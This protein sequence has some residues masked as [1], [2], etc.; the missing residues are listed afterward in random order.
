MS[1]VSRF[2]LNNNEA[3]LYITLILFLIGAVNVFSASFVLAGQLLHDSYFFLKHHL[4]A[5]AIGFIAL[6][7]VS[8]MDY[9]HVRRL[10]LF[11]ILATTGLLIAVHLGGVDANGARRWLNLAG[12]KFQPSEIAKLVTIIM[13][14]SY[15]GGL[16][17]RRR[18]ASLHSVPFYFSGICAA[19]VLK[20]P[21]MGTALIIIGVPMAMYL[22]VGLPRIQLFLLCGGGAALMAL[23]TYGAAY[24][25]ER[26]AAWLNPWAYQQTIGYQTVQSLL[27]IGSGGF[28]G[29][30]LGMGA[31]KFYYLPEAHTDF[32][33]AVLCQEMGFAGAVVVLLLFAI[34]GCYGGIIARKAPDGFGKM[35]A[36][37]STGLVVG[38]AIVN[39]A[40]VSGVIPVIGVPLPF[41]SFGGTS[42]IVNL[43]AIGLLISV[44]RRAVSRVPGQSEEIPV[45]TRPPRRR[46]T[47]LH[48]RD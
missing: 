7:V 23:G 34:L 45:E 8:R 48:N 10:L 30:G 17:D 19:I 6:L 39:I 36:L 9:H 44:G 37:G 43:I 25:A 18:L 2:W 47:L 31:S 24:R 29:T 13:S 40:M 22:V 28:F 41:I 42:L 11:L 33:F 4:V 26:V 15:L 1:K 38:Q 46:L 32:A 20:Q 12:L 3:V 5:F 35:L 27:A 21:D 16:L 14:S